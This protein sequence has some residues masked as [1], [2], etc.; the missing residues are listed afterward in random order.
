M[1]CVF[2]GPHPISYDVA[3]CSIQETC[4][5]VAADQPLSAT[6]AGSREEVP[7]LHEEPIARRP[8]RSRPS[9][10]EIGWTCAHPNDLAIRPRCDVE[11]FVEL[12]DNSPEPQPV[13]EQPR[14]RRP[15]AWI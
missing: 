2:F 13:Q 7:E 3:G 4:W 1:A 9:L 14:P 6:S 8:R 10:R 5:E 15:H 11:G 12:F